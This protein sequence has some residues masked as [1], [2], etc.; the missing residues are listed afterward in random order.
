M[1]TMYLLIYLFLCLNQIPVIFLPCTHSKCPL[2][3]GDSCVIKKESNNEGTKIDKTAN[4]LNQIETNTVKKEQV[5][6]TRQYKIE[7][8]NKNIFFKNRTRQIKATETNK[9]VTYLN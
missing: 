3:T 2:W 1:F 6:K 9:K 5:N 8:F 4:V 7:M